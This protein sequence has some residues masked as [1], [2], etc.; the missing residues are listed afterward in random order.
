MAWEVNNEWED[1][2]KKLKELKL[3]PKPEVIDP[4]DI[5]LNHV[6]VACEYLGIDGERLLFSE[7]VVRLPKHPTFQQAQGLINT[8]VTNSEDYDIKGMHPSQVKA[9]L[10]GITA[11]FIKASLR[12]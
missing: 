1:D 7:D 2:S 10:A 4:E 8:I 9:F 6:I 5:T 12:V 11:Y 3:E